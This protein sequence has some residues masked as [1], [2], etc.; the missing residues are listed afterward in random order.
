MFRRGTRSDKSRHEQDDRREVRKT[1]SPDWQDCNGDEGQ[2]ARE[3][4]QLA[5]I[6]SP[7]RKNGTAERWNKDHSDAV[8]RRINVSRVQ[9]PI[10]LRIRARLTERVRMVFISGPGLLGQ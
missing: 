1:D 6:R 10:D 2:D 9:V 5:T 8:P 7:Q 3:S 4:D